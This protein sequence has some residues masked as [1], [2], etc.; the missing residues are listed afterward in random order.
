MLREQKEIII[1]T[2][3]PL[4]FKKLNEKRDRIFMMGS[5]YGIE[6][7]SRSN[8]DLTRYV[9]QVSFTIYQKHLLINKWSQPTEVSSLF[10]FEYL[11]KQVLREM[12][13]TGG[14]KLPEQ[15]DYFEPSLPFEE[16]EV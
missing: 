14:L 7:V 9:H 3:E 10:A 15:K 4:G 8:K 2:L 16:G 13:N 5:E 12:G 1:K 11:L 6:C